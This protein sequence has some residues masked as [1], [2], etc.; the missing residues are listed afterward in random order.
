ML[1]R[2]GTPASTKTHKAL[3]ALSGAVGGVFGLAGAAVEVPFTTTLTLRAIA[4]IAR[5]EG[6]DIKDAA[7]RV[8]CTTVLSMGSESSDDDEALE[9]YFTSRS[10]LAHIAAKASE[11]VAK[12]AAK[13]GLKGFS[14]GDAGSWVGQLIVKILEK[15]GIPLTSRIAA[16][17]VP[18][19]SAVSAATLNTL[20]TD[21]Y[22]TIARGHFI[23]RRLENKYGEDAIR[24]AMKDIVDDRRKPVRPS[25]AVRRATGASRR[26]A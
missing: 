9:G 19:I 2:P 11:E 13:A 3:T 15:F 20:F 6:F 18:V 24:T 4:D 16:G 22:Q 1:D 10:A 5:S 23:T 17:A 25:D 8:D 7:V 21:Y 12:A 14:T 26:R